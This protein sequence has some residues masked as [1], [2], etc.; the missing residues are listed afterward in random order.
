MLL[1]LLRNIP[2]YCGKHRDL[3]ARL[4]SH[5]PTYS[6]PRAF[7]L[8]RLMK[9]EHPDLSMA[10]IEAYLMQPNKDSPRFEARMTLVRESDGESLV[11]DTF[12]SLD[13]F[14]DG[15]LESDGETGVKLVPFLKETAH[16]RATV[17]LTKDAAVNAEI[18]ALNNERFYTP[19]VSA[20]EMWYQTQ[21]NK[22]ES[23]A[24]AVH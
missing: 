1:E 20:L 2:Y 7:A 16:V 17:A 14:V 21:E 10:H 12:W 18:V 15:V 5:A 9:W 4:Q 23:N 24:D 13:G 22:E 6:K 3:V 8:I 11:F 19:D